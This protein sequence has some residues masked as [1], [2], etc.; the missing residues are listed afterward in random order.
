MDLRTTLMLCTAIGGANALSLTASAR[1]HTKEVERPNILWLT[2]E[3][4][5]A[6]EF[7]CYGNQFV[8]TPVTDSLASIG[9]QFMNAWSSAPQSSPARS[10]IITGCYATTYGMDFHPYPFDTPSDIFFPQR[11]RDA[12]YYCINNSKTH[13]NSTEDNK[14]CWDDCSKTA[15]Y[16]SPERGDRPFFAVFNT[17][18][19]HMGRIRTFHVD[20]RRDYTT[21]G[22]NPRQLIIP[23]YLPDLPEVRLDYAADLEG[24]QDVDGW[25]GYFLDD[26][27]TKGLDDNTIV[28]FFSDHG[29]CLPRGKG[30]LYE[31]G[32]QVPMVVYF[33]V[34]WQHLANGLVGKTD[35]LV[36]FTDLGPTVLSL[37]GIKPDKSMQGEAFFGKYAQEER[38][39]NYAFAANQ[40]HHFMP[41]RAVS[42]GHYKLI[43][44]Y[45]PYRQFAMRNYYQWGM[46]SNK[47]WDELVL[48]AHNANSGLSEAEYRK[49]ID[50]VLLQPFDMHPALMLFD[51]DVD[52]YELNDLSADPEYAEVLARMSSVMSAHVRS[53]GDLGFFLPTTRA[54]YN[55][56]DAVHKSKVFGKDFLPQLHNLVERAGLADISDEPLFCEAL[57]SPITEMRFWAAV[58]YG[59]LARHGLLALSTVSSTESS[60]VQ[61]DQC[62]AELLSLIGDSDPYVAAEAAYAC[63]YLGH[64]TDALNYL[65]YGLTPAQGDVNAQNYGMSHSMS[66]GMGDFQNH[67]MGDSHNVGKSQGH[68]QLEKMDELKIKYSALECISL[69]IE[70]KALILPYAEALAHAAEFLPRTKNEDPGLMVRGILVNLGLMDIWDMHGDESYE[71]GL[72]FNHGRRR[73]LP[74]P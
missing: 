67:G 59:T 43:R 15:S 55:L 2:F 50:P 38:Q 7:G 23:P 24:V 28:F 19:C 22:I 65:V 12:G 10:S 57:K 68:K 25:L 63:A 31:T 36:N 45:I 54:K 29:G 8:H 3:D 1:Q 17:T 32:L 62:P 4:K 40:L 18:C 44:S 48:G 14:A 34:K 46:P 26:L 58:G 72:R 49:G 35:R 13:Y 20:G 52:P 61:N 70:K 39:Y 11:L 16:N 73:A 47:A 53:T 21:E 71:A 33:P 51:L 42:D 64:S 60:S 56:Y 6:Y 27:K 37:A 30:Y 9:V 74:L 69:D 5:S 41:V 66:H